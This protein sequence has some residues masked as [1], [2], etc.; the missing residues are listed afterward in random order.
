MSHLEGGRETLA[1]LGVGFDAIKY[2]AKGTAKI[3]LPKDVYNSI[4]Q[5]YN[6]LPRGV[7]ILLETALFS[8]MPVGTV[9]KIAG[10]TIG[11]MPLTDV[12]ALLAAK[13][14]PK[15]PLSLVKSKYYNSPKP[16]LA[17][18]GGV[19]EVGKIS[20][21][22]GE[23]TLTKPVPLEIKP[24]ASIL[25]EVDDFGLAEIESFAAK[26]NWHNLPEMVKY[27]PEGYNYV[28]LAQG[29]KTIGV[30]FKKGPHNEIVFKKAKI[31]P[32]YPTQ[33]VDYVSYTKNGSQHVTRDG[34]FI[35]EHKG[36]MI[37]ADKVGQKTIIPK[38]ELQRLG[39]ETSE[40]HPD[41]HIP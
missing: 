11:K 38:Q 10:K 17:I 1:A 26:H 21:G 2:L 4:A 29:D 31:N 15:D 3:V 35:Y 8:A 24:T 40:Y 16:L 34:G 37:W 22:L 36:T 41:V 19:G 12:P 30:V 18:E 32:K 9:V 39:I 28:G 25:S 27:V 5:H 13:P 33:E 7:Q 23:N 14:I 6:E 20:T